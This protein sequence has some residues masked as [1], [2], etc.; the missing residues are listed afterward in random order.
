MVVRVID[1]GTGIEPDVQKRIFDPFFTT[2]P[3]GEGTGLGLDISQRIVRAHDGSIEVKSQPGRTEFC[4]SFPA[5]LPAAS[6]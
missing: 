2:K 6:T 5:V 3:V 1:N 4:V